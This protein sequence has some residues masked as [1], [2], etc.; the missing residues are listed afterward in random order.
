MN[1]LRKYFQRYSVLLIFVI[2]IRIISA[3]WL[4]KPEGPY[5]SL[6]LNLD[7][8][9]MVVLGWCLAEFL[10]TLFFKKVLG[11]FEDIKYS[12]VPPGDLV[13]VAIFLFRGLL[14]FATILALCTGL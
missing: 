9:C 14:Y 13:T 7:K 2:P 8:I 12:E 6:R 1:A 10:W 11:K 4:Y 3:T 5:N